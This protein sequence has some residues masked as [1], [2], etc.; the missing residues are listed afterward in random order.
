[1]TYPPVDPRFHRRGAPVDPRAGLGPI[2]AYYGINDG[3]FLFPSYGSIT[4]LMVNSAVA[5]LSVVKQ[6]AVAQIPAP[7]IN[8]SLIFEKWT[9]IG[10][11]KK[12]DDTE[13]P[14]K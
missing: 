10:D 13:N 2:F 7:Q 8:T 6:N 5:I 14:I 11:R 9:Q 1:M 12:Q 3:D 4:D